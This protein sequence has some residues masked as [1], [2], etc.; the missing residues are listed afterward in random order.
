MFILRNIAS[1]LKNESQD[2]LKLILKS[3]IFYIPSEFPN[4]NDIDE[5]IYSALALDKQYNV[6]SNVSDDVL[7]SFINN[8]VYNKNLDIQK[9]NIN[10]YEQLAKEFD[11]MKDVIQMHKFYIALANKK[12]AL[13][14]L[15]NEK[16][17]TIIIKLKDI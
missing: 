7:Q 15:I 12:E 14:K 5:D 13:T 2:H 16:N 8:W 11:R 9:D 1:F 17:S 10:Q 4:L 6:L 3:K